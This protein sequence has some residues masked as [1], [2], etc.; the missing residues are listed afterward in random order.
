M[1][2][3]GFHQK[4]DWIRLQFGKLAM[5]E[6]SINICW[7]HWQGRHMLD[8]TEIIQVRNEK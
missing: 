1:E 2:T 4:S 7:S 6:G 8:A 3:E 5:T